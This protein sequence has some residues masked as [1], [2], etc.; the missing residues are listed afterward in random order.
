MCVPVAVAQVV[1]P[2]YRTWASPHCYDVNPKPLLVTIGFA[3]SY[4]TLATC[5]DEAAYHGYLYAGIHNGK[6]CFAGNVTRAPLVPLS[7]C[8]KACVSDPAQVC[9]GENSTIIYRN[10]PNFVP[11]PYINLSGWNWLGCSVD[12]PTGSSLRHGVGGFP[13]TDTSHCLSKCVGFKL[14][15]IRN[16]NQCFCGNALLNDTPLLRSFGGPC[17]TGCEENPREE[18]GGPNAHT[19]YRHGLDPITSGPGKIIQSYDGWT[20]SNCFT[21]MGS[22]R[23]LSNS[24]NFRE[25]MTLEQCL[26][27]CK[28][29]GF[30]LAGVE[31]GQECYC[32]N[33]IQPP[34]AVVTSGCDAMQCVS[35]AGQLCGGPDRLLVYE[36]TNS[37]HSDA[38]ALPTHALFSHI[39]SNISKGRHPTCPTHKPT[40]HA[41]VLRTRNF[42]VLKPAVEKAWKELG[43]QGDVNPD[44]RRHD[45]VGPSPAFCKKVI[46]DVLDAF[47]KD[48]W[49]EIYQEIEDEWDL[50]K[51]KYL[52]EIME[53]YGEHDS[54]GL[55]YSLFDV[56]HPLLNSL[57]TLTGMS[58]TL[59]AGGPFSEG[60]GLIKFVPPFHVFLF[61][62]LIDVFES[63][64][65]E[66]KMNAPLIV[67]L[68]Q[69]NQFTR[70]AQGWMGTAQS[71]F[72]EQ[73]AEATEATIIDYYDK[74][75]Y[76]SPASDGSTTTQE[77]HEIISAPDGAE[78]DQPTPAKPSQPHNT[79]PASSNTQPLHNLQI[80]GTTPKRK[81]VLDSMP[82]FLLPP[83]KKQ[84][85]STTTRSTSPPVVRENPQDLNSAQPPSINFPSGSS[86]EED[87]GC[88]AGTATDP[89]SHSKGPTES[90]SP[91]TTCSTQI[92]QNQLLAKPVHPERQ[93]ISTSASVRQA[94]TL[95]SINTTIKNMPTYLK[96]LST[97]LPGI[98]E[99]DLGPQYLH[100]V[101]CLIELET[102]H[103][104]NIKNGPRLMFINRPE[105]VKKWITNGR[106]CSYRVEIEDLSQY[107]ALWW[108]WWRSLQ[109]KWR[110]YD[111][112][113][114]PISM[115]PSGKVED[116]DVLFVPGV[117]GLLSVVASLYWWGCAV[118]RG[119]GKA[120]EDGRGWDEA[121]RDCEWVMERLIMAMKR[122]RRSSCD[123]FERD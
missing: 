100:I 55:V 65:S 79:S 111:S 28:A 103:D 83:R 66:F 76:D 93:C 33:A 115:V 48:D 69:G 114:I 20:V 19:V 58:F 106:R 6:T 91:N 5:L 105:E 15:G 1:V 32:G 43:R 99:I 67:P 4:M 113:G 57:G 47:S 17:N 45:G 77:H 40:P 64:S 108:R 34:G 11:V 24:V 14:V 101:K 118:A 109:P 74:F 51:G 96:W 13:S 3:D 84:R 95:A 21:D 56:L 60:I 97:V 59:W 61:Y 90:A 104:F 94:L 112:A 70:I 29:Q 31:Y 36:L 81:K 30:R 88:S 10:G 42:S 98:V 54:A 85:T 52:D 122:K 35:N 68:T 78:S 102:L 75:M 7:Y 110:K 50:T 119:K 80:A 72:L 82:P 26:N 71:D 62:G 87:S 73:C 25:D 9:G 53:L 22:N 120:K 121:A 117:N 89:F 123:E 49:E 44:F 2:S 16:G 116:W 37:M 18:C 27:S 63:V 41:H 46:R 12:S 23:T 38:S 8:N 92:G 107:T 39:L 86:L